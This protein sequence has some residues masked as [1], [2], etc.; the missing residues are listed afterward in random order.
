MGYGI[1]L[2]PVAILPA[3][4]NKHPTGI[5][6]P[7]SAVVHGYS[8]GQPDLLD[9]GV[10][11]IIDRGPTLCYLYSSLILHAEDAPQPLMH[12]WSGSNVTF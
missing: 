10:L 4:A 12:Q 2:G 3:T 11:H 5:E 8:T 7:A 9:P 1:Y 6:C